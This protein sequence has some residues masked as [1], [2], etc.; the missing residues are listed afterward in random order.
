MSPEESHQPVEETTFDLPKKDAFKY[1]WS[2]YIS[3]ELYWEGVDRVE[4]KC[5]VNRDAPAYKTPEERLAVISEAVKEKRDIGLTPPR[6]GHFK[7]GIIGAGAAGLFTAL[8][9]DWIN[10]TIERYKG[11]GKLKIEYEILEAAS[12]DRFGG[13]LFTHHFSKDGIHDY[14]DVGAMRFPDNEV[15][16]RSFRLFDYLDIKKGAL[17]ER[18][19]VKDWP[20]LIPYYLSDE[21]KVCPSYFNNIQ[22]TGSPWGNAVDPLTNKNPSDLYDEALKPFVDLVKKYFDEKT[23]SC[24]KEKLWA[25]LK[26]GDQMSVRQYLLSKTTACQFEW[27]ETATYGTGWYDQG[28]TEAALEIL[29][30][31]VPETK[32]ELR[33]QN[34]YWWCVDGGAQTIAETMRKTMKDPS[35]IKYNTQVVGMDANIQL[36]KR[37]KKNM[38]LNLKDTVTGETLESKSYFAVFNSA[39]LGATNRMD[40]SNAGLLWDTKQAIR[41]LNYGASCKVGIKFRTPWWRKEPFNITRGGLGRTDLP[42]QVCVYPSYNIDNDLDPLDKPAV[43]LVSY[44]WGQ[45][46]QRLATLIASKSI[47]KSNEEIL[48]EEI[49]LRN[50]LLRD[51]AFLHT[52]APDDPTEE[53]KKFKKT[54]DLISGEYLEHHAYDWYHDPHM[55]GA[56]AY[57]GPCQFSELYPAITR[58]NALG[59]LYFVGEAAS[60]HHAWVVGALESVVRALWSMFNILHQSSQDAGKA[61]QPYSWAMQLLER[62]FF[63][64]NEDPGYNADDDK[65]KTFYPSAKPQPS[66]FF[67]LPVEIPLRVDGETHGQNARCPDG[68]EL[69]DHIDPKKPPMFGAACANLALLEYALDNWAGPGKLRKPVKSNPGNLV[70]WKPEDVNK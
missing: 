20:V 9:L 30:F 5:F 65:K 43:L 34:H 4:R 14:Y 60:A 22:K 45:T 52:K 11:A 59:Q 62:G 16:S 50:L 42:L 33:P 64:D 13:R 49:E 24:G 2:R 58:P 55:A 10:D 21:D 40:L 44:T 53:R 29:D 46:A 68:K 18:T 69:L 31:E 7:V 3:R 63:E 8:A 15:M 25:L 57:F 17:G 12:K 38:H 26:K 39:T 67:P 37:I 19:N 36:E 35:V 23:T 32:P 70:D 66:P 6:H 48:K 56:F 1:Q 28:L 47:N 27:L 54:L 41:C 51:L 61:Y